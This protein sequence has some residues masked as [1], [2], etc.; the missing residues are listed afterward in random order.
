MDRK[1]DLGLFGDTRW[2]KTPGGT[3]LDTGIGDSIIS[4]NLEKSGN[5]NAKDMFEKLKEAND[6]IDDN[7]LA[8]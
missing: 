1:I 2:K 7:I 3:V 5:E 8:H 4:K 6:W